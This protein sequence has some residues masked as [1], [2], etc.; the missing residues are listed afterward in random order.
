M[1]KIEYRSRRRMA[2]ADVEALVAL[3]V[4]G[5]ES[6]WPRLWQAIEPRLYATLRR[7]HFLGRLSESEDHCRNI[8]VEVMSRL[9]ADDHARLRAYVEARREKPGLVF[10][11]WLIVVAKRVGID[12]LRGLDTYID[13]RREAGASRPGGWQLLDTLI[14]DSRSPGQAPRITDAATAHEI[15]AFAEELPA[16]QQAALRSWLQ[17]RG[18]DE[19]AAAH[20]FPDGRAAERA[21][22]AGLERIRR[23]FRQEDRS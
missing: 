15:L 3:V 10:R 16:E 19:I 23:R 17:G 21:L 12:Y 22:R 6:A 4:A 11:A 2:D 14:A 5:D 20:G 9:R 18:Y 1:L 8:V 7:P 13:R